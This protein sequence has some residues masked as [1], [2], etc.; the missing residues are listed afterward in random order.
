VEAGE[1]GTGAGAVER[2]GPEGT[3]RRGVQG[4]RK[5]LEKQGARA[6]DGMGKGEEVE[7]QV[8]HWPR[9][10][11]EVSRTPLRLAKQSR[12]ELQEL[13]QQKPVNRHHRRRFET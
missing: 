5:A 12:G 7:E 2:K 3:S 8:G 4:K 6:G 13:V 10:T 1:E 9:K 11:R